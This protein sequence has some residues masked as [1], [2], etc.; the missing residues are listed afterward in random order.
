MEKGRSH[1][2]VY[3]TLLF[4]DTGSTGREQ[5]ARLA[6]EARIVGSGTVAGQLYDLGR[7]P[8]LVETSEARAR[9]RGDVLELA[10]PERT[11]RWLDAYEGI[12]PGDHPHNPYQ[13]IEVEAALENGGSVT[14][15]VYLYRLA[16]PEHRLIAGGSWLDR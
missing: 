16:P 8:G 3:G 1:L 6:R 10:A 11:L 14:A 7:Y 15:W 12:V 2:F 9:V 5:R 4:A 13:R